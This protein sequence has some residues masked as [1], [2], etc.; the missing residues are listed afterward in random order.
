MIKNQPQIIKRLLAEYN[1]FGDIARDVAR[2]T[3]EYEHGTYIEVY[4]NKDEKQLRWF[5]IGQNSYQPLDDGEYYVSGIQCGADA[6]IELEN[7]IEKDEDTGERYIPAD[8]YHPRIEE[9]DF[10]EFLFGDD[11]DV[12]HIAEH[13]RQELERRAKNLLEEIIVTY[14]EQ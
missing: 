3:F 2:A 9:D 4:F 6:C 7:D 8:D 11:C 12:T 5:P 1:P 14:G 10:V 13:T